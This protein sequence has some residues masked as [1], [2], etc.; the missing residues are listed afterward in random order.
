[1][2]IVAGRFKGRH[3]ARPKNNKIR[4][5]S[6]KIRGAI[7]NILNS[8]N[9]IR[10]AIVLDGFCG[11][12]ALGL[13]ALSRGASSC[14]FIDSSRESL[15]LCENNINSLDV[16]NQTHSLL[17]D[18][19]KNC[20]KPSG[21]L[22]C[23]LAF[24]DPPYR[25]DFITKALLNLI[26]ENWIELGCTIVCEEEKSAFIELPAGITLVDQRTYGDTQ[27]LFTQF[28]STRMEVLS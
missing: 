27:I 5:T 28:V 25:K 16:L 11:T 24:L 18:L 2:R 7:F 26:N 6:D 20:V 19:T 22:P 3:L 10:D 17:G 9:L 1:M 13:E 14:V 8:Q 23:T 12:G 15:H 21:I 4:P